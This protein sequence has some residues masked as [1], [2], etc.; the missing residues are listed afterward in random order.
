MAE[1]TGSHSKKKQRFF[2]VLRLPYETY[3]QLSYSV[4]MDVFTNVL[5]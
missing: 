3:E 5:T 2:I 1:Y 4:L